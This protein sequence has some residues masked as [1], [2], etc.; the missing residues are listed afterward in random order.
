M[1]ICNT[2]FHRMQH[3]VPW[4]MQASNLPRDDVSLCMVRSIRQKCV[5]NNADGSTSVSVW[6]AWSTKPRDGK[7]AGCGW[8][9]DQVAEA[10]P[11]QKGIPIQMQ[12]SS[13]FTPLPYYTLT[14]WWMF[15]L[16]WLHLL[17]LS[18]YILWIRNEHRLSVL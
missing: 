7:S 18:I 11:L 15:Y 10:R 14:Y 2:W 9:R 12:I 13:G 3:D 1:F 8:L 17:M 6:L 16:T 4:F 5:W